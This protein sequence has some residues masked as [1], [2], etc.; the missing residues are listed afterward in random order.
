M[1]GRLPLGACRA[2][3]LRREHR[4]FHRR[5]LLELNIPAA[6]LVKLSKS[7]IQVR[8]FPDLQAE[9]VGLFAEWRARRQEQGVLMPHADL[10]VRCLISAEQIAGRIAEMV[11]QITATPPAATYWWSACSRLVHLHGRPGASLPTTAHCD[12]VKVSSFT[13]LGTSSGQL[14]LHL[15]VSLPVAGRDVLL[16]E[17]VVDTD[18]AR[19]W[20]VEHLRRGRRPGPPCALLD[21]PSRRSSP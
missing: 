6:E 8:L 3:R 15:D 1:P 17:D 9:C 13:G 10:H 7:P 2:H 21:K 16:V 5:R 19:A 12:F 11:R 18:K 4:R 20:L 14:N